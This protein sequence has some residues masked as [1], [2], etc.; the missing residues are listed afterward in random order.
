MTHEVHIQAQDR[1]LLVV[2]LAG[3]RPGSRKE[4]L[5]SRS[6]IVA[7]IVVALIVV[8]L[9]GGPLAPTAQA[10]PAPGPD[11]NGDGYADLAVGVPGEDLGTTVDAGMVSVVY[12]SATGLTS[13]GNQ[14]WQQDIGAV[15][16]IS[17]AGDR[18]GRAVTAGDFNTDGYADLAVGVPGEDD[19]AGAVNVLYGGP[20]GLGDRGNAFLRQAHGGVPGMHEADDRFGWAVAS[21]DVNGDGYADLAAGLPGED[22]R[23]S[24]DAGAAIVLYGSGSGISSQGAQMWHQASPNVAGEIEADD[25]F[26]SALA[27]GD[28]DGDG[29]DDLAIGVPGEDVNGYVDAGVTN[30]LVGSATGLVGDGRWFWYQNGTIIGAVDHDEQFGAAL[31]VSDLNGDGFADLA[32]GVPGEDQWSGAVNVIYGAAGGLTSDGNQRWKQGFAGLRA[33]HEPGDRFGEALT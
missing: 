3:V 7:L 5:A 27:A 4:P 10:A 14:L 19:G 29:S 20:D 11:F 13:T 18:F 9:I 6:L 21:G 24:V 26:G 28:F 32:N 22:L 2:S 15:I 16:G 25:R 12:G 17:E 8:A 31:T 1:R 33:S 23:S 30:V